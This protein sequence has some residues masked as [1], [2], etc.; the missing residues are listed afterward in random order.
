MLLKEAQKI[1]LSLSAL[2]NVIN[3]LT[4]GRAHIP[5]RSV[6]G[7][8]G[9]VSMDMLGRQ[10]I[11]KIVSFISKIPIVAVRILLGFTTAR[12]ARISNFKRSESYAYITSMRKT[13]RMD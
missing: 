12:S 4:E 10:T 3:A 9:G 6:G 8:G 7:K 5:Y 13:F 1:N 2:G 11:A